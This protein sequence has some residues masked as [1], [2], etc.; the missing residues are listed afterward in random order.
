MKVDMIDAYALATVKMRAT[1]KGVLY[2]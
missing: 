2:P 1:D